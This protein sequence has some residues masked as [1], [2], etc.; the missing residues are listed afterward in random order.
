[1]TEETIGCGMRAGEGERR[2]GMVECCRLPRCHRMA[3]GAVVRELACH[4]I[5]RRRPCKIGLMACDAI[6]RQSGILPVLMACR[7][8]GRPM[9]AEQ[10][11]IRFAMIKRGGLPCVPRMACR[12]VVRELA[13][14]MVH[15]G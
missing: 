7:T 9:G 6:C 12:A 5:R 1:M 15:R 13:G 14:D 11:E 4:M 2:F 3:R 10:R 8:I